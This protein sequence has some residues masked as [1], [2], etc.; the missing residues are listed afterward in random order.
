MLCLAALAARPQPWPTYGWSTADPAAHGLDPARLE[1]ACQHIARNCPTRFSLLV[2]RNG[3]L[4][5]ERYFNGS[6]A[7]QANNIKS[8]SKSILAVLTGMAIEEGRIRGVEQKLADFYPEYFHENLDPRKFDITLEHLLTMRAGFEW[9]ENTAISDRMWLSSDWHRHIIDSPLT[10]NPGEVWNYNTG[11]SHL[12]SGILT[13]VS[14]IS[15]RAYAES[16]L[17][18]PLGMTCHRWS[19]DPRGYYFGGSEVWLTARDLARF[20]LLALRRGRWE[21]RQLVSEQWMAE[22]MRMRCATTSFHSAFPDRDYG[23]H[24]W[25]I[26]LSGHPAIE[27]SGYGGQNIFLFPDLDLMVVTTARSDIPLT[28]WVPYTEPYDFINRFILPAVTREPPAMA[29]VVNA[30]DYT[31]RLAAGSF[32][33]L[34]GSGLAVSES[35]W[36]YAVAADGRLPVGIGG[37]RIW[38][39]SRPAHPSYAGPGQVNFL[40]P[41]DLGA[42]RHPMLLMT[43]RGHVTGEVE[44]HTAAPAWFLFTRDGRP[45]A[46]PRPVRPGEVIELYASGLGASD[47]PARAGMALAA[48]APLPRLPEV[49][50]S[51]REAVVWWAGQIYAGVYQINVAVPHE[52]PAGDAAVTLRFD[53]ETA[54]HDAVVEV[55]R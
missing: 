38:I 31:D 39:G 4:V 54:P 43:P 24:W 11:L 28:S 7:A 29:A 30:A 47:P 2:V 55:L 17:F 40:V 35:D 23:Y 21:D 20:G 9:A 49:L 26:N 33:S 46:C 10:D 51:G 16:R 12:V 13:T 42:G 19:Q 44:I 5:L 27:A 41:P 37:V 14:G 6:G 53:G 50:V 32:A 3:Y 36:G 1:E 34:F 45:L 52:T 18:G 25:G 48:P 8:M 15:T 22:S